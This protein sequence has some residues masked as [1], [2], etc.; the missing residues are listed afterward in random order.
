MVNILCYVRQ[1]RLFLMLSFFCLDF[2][3]FYQ[4]LA[5]FFNEENF[6]LLAM[7][8]MRMHYNQLVVI[9]DFQ[10]MRAALSG[11][12]LMFDTKDV[13]ILLKYLIDTRMKIP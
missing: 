5:K 10:P 4:V 7:C 2:A 8:S 1:V 6:R 12:H 9:C 11:C 3:L 13:A